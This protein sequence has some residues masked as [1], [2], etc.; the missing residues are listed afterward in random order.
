MKKI[1]QLPI[2]FAF[3]AICSCNN[4]LFHGG[5]KVR[6]KRDYMCPNVNENYFYK[7]AGVKPF[8]VQ[9]TSKLWY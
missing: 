1:T 4:A 6:H 5:L 9:K 7:E 2:L 8:R 3:M